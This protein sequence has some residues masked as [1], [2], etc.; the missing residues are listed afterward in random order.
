MIED[1]VLA[2]LGDEAFLIRAQQIQD[3]DWVVVDGKAN[4]TLG[5]AFGAFAALEYLGY[6]FMHPLEPTQPLA[7][8]QP[9]EMPF[10][11]SAALP[12]VKPG[13]FAWEPPKAA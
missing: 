13:G 10:E 5:P 3:V 9:R 6:A 2:E 11:L 1:S 4:D 8:L 7:G 12:P